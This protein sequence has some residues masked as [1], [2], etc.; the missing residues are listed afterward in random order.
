M[1]KRLQL[2]LLVFYGLK[3]LEANFV[4]IITT[5]QVV[6]G[7]VLFCSLHFSV[8]LKFLIIEKREGMS[9]FDKLEEQT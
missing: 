1:H 6:N 8:V 3:K 7:C 9:V 4:K 5:E 2:Y